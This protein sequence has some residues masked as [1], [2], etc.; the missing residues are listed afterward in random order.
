[1]QVDSHPPR[2]QSQRSSLWLHRSS[3]R[4][5]CALP[6]RPNSE[7]ESIHPK[8]DPFTVEDIPISESTLVNQ[9]RDFVEDIFVKGCPLCTG[10]I[11]QIGQ[12]LQ[13]A[14][15][16]DNVG[17]YVYPFRTISSIHPKLV[18][19]TVAAFPRLGWSE[20][21][22]RIIEKE[23][24][25][26]PWSTARHLRFRRGRAARD[27]LKGSGLEHFFDELAEES[28]PRMFSKRF[29]TV[30]RLAVQSSHADKAASQSNSQDS[31]IPRRDA[32]SLPPPAAASNTSQP[33]RDTASRF[34][35]V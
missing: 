14:T 18:E 2:P 33:E 8:Q 25:L 12:A 1:M 30:R 27:S 29:D 3:T 35:L 17:L 15:I 5:R 6:K 16:L 34:G 10:N 26:K 11:T 31:D 19:R 21:F 32:E 20:H 28:W 24:D 7:W 23:L 13:L 9:I 4:S 22:A